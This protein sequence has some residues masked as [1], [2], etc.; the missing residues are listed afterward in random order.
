MALGAEIVSTHGDNTYWFFFQNLR[1]FSSARTKKNHRQYPSSVPP[2]KILSHPFAV[3][4]IICICAE[5]I[6][7]M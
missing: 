4:I 7:K 3:R 5:S 1:E 2:C 6:M